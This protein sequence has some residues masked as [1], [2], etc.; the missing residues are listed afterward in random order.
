MPTLRVHKT[1]IV[2]EWKLG[3]LEAAY[4]APTHPENTHRERHS[5]IDGGD[6]AWYGGLRSDSEAREILTGGWVD[7]VSRLNDLRRDLGEI[8]T[9]KCR[10][11]RVRFADQGDDLVIDRAMRGDWDQAWRTSRREQT[12]GPQ[13]IELFT[14]Y[15]GACSLDADEI[16]YK[17]A[18]ATVVA[19]ALENAGYS[20]RLVAS[21]M[22]RDTS[23]SSRVGRSDIILKEASEPLRI[24]GVASVLCHAGIFRSYGFRVL[25]ALPFELNSALGPAIYDWPNEI[26]KMRA[27]GEWNDGCIAVN[28]VTTRYGATCEI[29]RILQSVNAG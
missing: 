16:F 19:D 9:A 13:T 22:H 25:M 23:K 18:V 4:D 14:L 27:A 26:E 28:P 8:P 1:A 17:G 29:A 5:H 7:G 15:G 3:E 6:A 24:D 10:V 2:N 11:R 20:V 12:S 21:F